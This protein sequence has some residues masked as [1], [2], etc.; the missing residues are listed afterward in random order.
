MIKEMHRNSKKRNAILEC[1]RQ[2]D[3]H[4]NAEWIYSRLKPVFPDLSMATV[5]RN[6]R[7]LQEEGVIDTL[8]AVCGQERFDGDTAPHS[9]AVCRICGKVLDL[10]LAPLPEEWL[11]SAIDRTGF[12]LSACAVQLTGV[13][14][15][16]SAKEKL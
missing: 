6:L 15:E 2:T 3:S 4:P 1:L 5:Y 13:C 8:G 12:S 14:K 16:C 10:P 11:Q 7:M 9:H